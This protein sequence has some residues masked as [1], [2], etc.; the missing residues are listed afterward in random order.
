MAHDINGRIYIGTTGV[1]IADVQAVL[2]LPNSDIGALI[3][4]GALYGVINKW[5]KCKPVRY[6]TYANSQKVPYPG[7]LTGDMWKG[8]VIS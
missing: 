4:Q 3:P 2:G 8:A 6:Y 5:A 1:E 7:L